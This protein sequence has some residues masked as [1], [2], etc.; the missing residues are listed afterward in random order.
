MPVSQYAP[1]G[2][3]ERVWLHGHDINVVEVPG[4]SGPMER[5]A[6]R[7]YGHGQGWSPEKGDASKRWWLRRKGSPSLSLFLSM[8]LRGSSIFSSL[9][10]LLM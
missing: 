9:S 5:K 8:K 6:Q 4:P 2:P 3:L 10:F 7:L 1:R